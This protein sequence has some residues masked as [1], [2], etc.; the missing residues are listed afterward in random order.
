MD[1][2]TYAYLQMG[3]EAKARAMVEELRAALAKGPLT[4]NFT[5]VA[6]IPARVALERGDWAGAAA[7]PVTDIKVAHADSLTRFA[8][9]IG[10]A[11]S[12]NL[13]GARGEIEALKALKADLDKT[14]KYW[15]ARTEEQM[16][17]VSAWIAKAEGDAAGAEKLL[18][19][20]ADSEDASVKNVQ[21]ENRLYP[22]REMYA[23]LLLENGKGAEAYPHYEVS[24]R[25][26]P[27][28]YRVLYGAAMAAHAMGDRVAAKRHFEALVALSKNA[29]GPRPELS[30]ARGMIA[31]Q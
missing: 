5:A 8:R 19:S 10:M 27:N 3:Q 7:L 13:A 15:A 22:L 23:E 30:R 31:L 29:D 11:R 9:G 4:T 24:L 14:S 21:M 17:A 2:M 6:C 18:K 1:F 20:A 26:T 25:E 12:G 16:F 28:R